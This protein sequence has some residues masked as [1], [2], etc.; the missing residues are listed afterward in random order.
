MD[1]NNF[2]N[3]IRN[4]YRVILL[5]SLLIIT[6]GIFSLLNLPVD[7]LP[8]RSEHVVTII[9]E[10][11]DIAPETIKNLI[12]K[13]LEDVLRNTYGVLNFYS[14]SSR[15]RSKIIC[16]FDIDENIDEFIIR[17][18][19]KIYDV[20][21]NFPREVRIPQIYKYNT[22]DSPVIILSVIPPSSYSEVEIKE[23]VEDSLRVELLALD[24]VAD[25]KLAGV[26]EHEYLV[27][28]N[29][30][31]IQSLKVDYTAIL[32]YIVNNNS[33]L[34]IGTLKKNDL[35]MD[36]KLLSRYK[37]VKEIDVSPVKVNNS[38]FNTKEIFT[39]LDVKKESKRF[40]MINGNRAIVF[41]IY[42][43]ESTSLLKMERAVTERFSNY[44]GHISWKV[45]YSRASD[46]R[47]LYKKLGIALIFSSLMILG[48]LFV[49][50]R[51]NLLLLIPLI[52]NLIFSFSGTMLIFYI[53]GKGINVISLAGIITGAL[54]SILFSIMALEIFTSEYANSNR[55]VF[56]FYCSTVKLK[57]LVNNN[58]IKVKKSIYSSVVINKMIQKSLIPI[59]SVFSTSTFIL[60]SLSFVD[61][62]WLTPYKDFMF[63]LV[64]VVAFSGLSVFFLFPLFLYKS[65]MKKYQ[66]L[67]RTVKVDFK[68]IWQKVFIKVLKFILT[69]LKYFKQNK[70]VNHKTDQ[71]KKRY[72]LPSRFK[73]LL[74]VAFLI[75]IS[76][77]F[78]YRYYALNYKRGYLLK[79]NKKEFFY[80]FNPG[81]TFK[82]RSGATKQIVT[83]LINRGITG[84]TG[85]AKVGYVL[86]SALEGDRIDFY[87]TEI[88]G[89]ND[90]L[91][92][93]LFKK[94]S[95]LKKTEN[96]FN[97]ARL[98]TENKRMDGFFYQK[99]DDCCELS[100]LRIMVF[101][102]DISRINEIVDEGAK[103][104]SE[105][106]GVKQIL[107]GYRK[108]IE[109]VSIVPD[110]SILYFYNLN[111]D[112]VESFLRYMFY[113][114]V[115]FKQYSDKTLV[116]VRAGFD[117]SPNSKVSVVDFISGIE[118]PLE[119][120]KNFIKIMDFADVHRKNV[121]SEISRKNGKPYISLDVRFLK[122]NEHNVLDKIVKVIKNLPYKFGEYYI[123][124]SNKD[125]KRDGSILFMNFIMIIFLIWILFAIAL[126]S[127]VLSLSVV[128]GIPFIFMGIYVF[129]RFTGGARSIPVE[130]AV[131][132]M[133]IFYVYAGAILLEK[134]ERYK[135]N[136]DFDGS[137]TG[138]N[139]TE[140]RMVF[141][142]FSVFIV[143]L[144]PIIFIQGTGYFFKVYSA[145]LIFSS[146]FI[147]IFLLAILPIVCIMLFH[148]SNF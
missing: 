11:P 99:E 26:P 33:A 24:D 4:N 70:L 117:V 25:V 1:C 29:Y 67:R 128:S 76:L 3:F 95:G 123:I 51:M 91:S 140:I 125:D 90:F 44:S 9:T 34:Q 75:G 111:C 104:I 130:I 21:R 141:R 59:F 14:F 38:I 48:L 56:E 5:V 30:D 63:P 120:G 136:S 72:F 96:D 133:T 145:S 40:S 85:S 135:N 98:I 37:N 57:S 74:L 55:F 46:L 54:F 53:S 82:Y 146:I 49:F 109:D 132:V 92:G 110:N 65:G 103:G 137:S 86:V 17:L 108:G 27:S 115:I 143:A 58:S 94:F 124:D 64:V 13:P 127:F 77:F 71:T 20:S 6:L 139:K 41:Y 15:G 102:D 42:R 16:Y 112:K 62:I 19:D 121:S 107:K 7:L 113:R 61:G 36:L 148:R 89:E 147:L 144:I 47:Y 28:M 114:P 68:K 50:Y 93:Y 8:S 22:D 2:V 80:Q 116:D 122:Q 60:L 78:M 106:A 73:T 23:L 119:K 31:T 66:I 134:F 81:Y 142:S 88:E 35:E 131:M 52:Y 79:E 32:K 43:N 105:I 12:T 84:R 118:V 100:S 101:G 83:E 45:L 18:N 138:F 69:G 87:L 39:V 97:I 10:Y 126:N 129:A